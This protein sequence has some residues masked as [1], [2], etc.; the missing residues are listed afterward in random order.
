MRL[1]EKYQKQIVPALKEEFG[2]KNI[3]L[4]P[5]LQKVVLNVGFG[6][7][8][9]DKDLATNVIK[10]LEMISGQKAVSTKAKKSIASFKLRQ[11]TV[12]G[13]MVTMRGARMYD[14]I[15]KLV[16]VSFPRVR[17]FR[18]IS[19]KSVDGRGNLTIGFKEHTAFPEIKVEDIN[20]THGLE[21]CIST[22]ATTRESGLALFKHLG[23][24]FKKN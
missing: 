5:K 10:T 19:D 12:I 20:N 24:P 2:Y 14:F 1:K 6:K 18:G 17:D 11:G 7:N 3:F 16:N 13:A 21:I 4:V 23:F 9:K 15:D 22:S 8:A